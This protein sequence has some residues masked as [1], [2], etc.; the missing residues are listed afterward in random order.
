[1]T[2]INVIWIPAA[3]AITILLINHFVYSIKKLNVHKTYYPTIKIH[4]TTTP[5]RIEIISAIKLLYLHGKIRSVY[6][7]EQYVSFE[8]DIPLLSG[9]IYYILFREP[10]VLSYRGKTRVYAIDKK[11]LA[12]IIFFFGSLSN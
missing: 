6:I 1:M 5:S 9:N 7:T 10:C 12:D 8:D 4:A 2:Y 11:K 3:A